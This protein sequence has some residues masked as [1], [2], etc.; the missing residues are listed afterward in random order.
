M[1]NVPD[2]LVKTGGEVGKAMGFI[3]ALPA[4]LV[5]AL[6]AGEW[7]AKAQSVLAAAV[8]IG[9]AFGEAVVK[10]APE[11][12]RTLVAGDTD[13]AAGVMLKLWKVLKGG[14]DQRQNTMLPE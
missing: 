11:L 13:A 1:S 7:G 8:A 14:D 4:A 6:F 10:G 2:A 3:V 12:A 5:I 9:Q